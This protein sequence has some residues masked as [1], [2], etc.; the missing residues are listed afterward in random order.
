MNPKGKYLTT[1]TQGP[2]NNLNMETRGIAHK[3]NK[4]RR[5]KRKK[6]KG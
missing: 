3:F 5:V 1:H 6:S 4:V 2:G